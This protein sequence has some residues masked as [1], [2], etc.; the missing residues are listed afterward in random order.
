MHIDGQLVFLGALGTLLVFLTIGYF[1]LSS[2]LSKTS[3]VLPVWE[4]L[5]GQP[6]LC[7][8]VGR[9]FTMFIKIR[10]PYARSIGI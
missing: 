3:Q 6:I 1:R 7:H 9:I 10:N 8:F 5:A 4:Y 2:A